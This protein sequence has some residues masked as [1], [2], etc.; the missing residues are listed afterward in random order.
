MKAR[1]RRIKIRVATMN[2]K[3]ANKK[4]ERGT[5]FQRSTARLSWTV[6]GLCIFS[7]LNVNAGVITSDPGDYVPFPDG[8]SLALLYYKHAERNDVYLKGRKQNSP[9]FGLDS[10]IAALRAV[11]YIQLGELLIAPNVILPFGR[12][13]QN[14]ASDDS[15]S[16]VADPLL[17]G[18]LWLVNDP[19]SRRYLSIGAWVAPPLGNYDAKDGPLNLGE[20]R[21]KGILHTSYSQPLIGNL[22]GEVTA[23]WDVFGKNDDF[24]GMT[25]RQSDIYELQTHLRYDFSPGNFAAVSY[26]DTRGGENELDGVSLDD[27]LNTK[28]YVISLAHMVTP[29]VQLLGQIGQDIDVENGP[30]EKYRAG[31]R[32]MKIF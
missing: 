8:T 7:S 22:V 17:G 24:A 16:G 2:N 29:S 12:L 20:N 15:T 13:K 26:Y 30:K 27:E 21:W 9:Q 11:H 10:D 25:R 31:L 23:E 18:A 32:L 4:L 6:F 5:G 1:K 28:R 3:S 19:Q 14:G